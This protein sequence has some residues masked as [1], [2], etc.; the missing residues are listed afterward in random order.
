[1]ETIYYIDLRELF[2]FSLIAL[3]ASIVMLVLLIRVIV[4]FIKGHDYRLIVVVIFVIVLL[5]IAFGLILFSTDSISTVC[6]IINAKKDQCEVVSGDFSIISVE[7]EYHRDD[8]LGYSVTFICEGRKF[9]AANLFTN[10][11]IEELKKLNEAK[12]SF[13]YIKKSLYIVKIDSAKSD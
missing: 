1:M 10:E 2:L 7:E 12:I 3:A 11:E 9:A 13:N 8:F 6:F 4:W 5:T